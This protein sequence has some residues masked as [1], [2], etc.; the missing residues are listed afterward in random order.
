MANRPLSWRT[1]DGL[2]GDMAIAGP[3]SPTYSPRSPNPRNRGRDAASG[4]AQAT[5]RRPSPAHPPRGSWLSRP[6]SSGPAA[7]GPSGSPE[8]PPACPARRRARWRL[9]HADAGAGAAE[10]VIVTPLLMLLVLGVI[11]FALAEQAQHAAQAA[12]TQA[13]A[14]T[15]V[16]D[17][18]VA[19]GQAQA[20]TVLAQVGGSLTAPAVSIT[21]TATQAR[22][23]VTGGVE[24]LIPGIHLHVRATVAGPVEEW[25]TGMGG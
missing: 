14:A 10:L 23:T 7:R 16:Q 6:M 9:P 17:G 2:V 12:A 4:R 20:A 8:D 21:R 1:R 5:D 13:L 15:R 22:V 24:S 19:A 25:T 11:Q 3:E 18:T